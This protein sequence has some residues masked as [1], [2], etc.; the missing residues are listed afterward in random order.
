MISQHKL[1]TMLI[2]SQVIVQGKSTQLVCLVVYRAYNMVRFVE[3][4]P[5][6]EG[7]RWSATL[8]IRLNHTTFGTWINIHRGI[9]YQLN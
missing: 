3:S 5:S 1:G 8:C 2:K 9:E 6:F 7:F 4:N